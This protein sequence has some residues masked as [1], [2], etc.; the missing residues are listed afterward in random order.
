MGTV[1]GLS[2]AANGLGI[3]LGSVLGGLLEDRIDLAA[4]FLFGGAVMAVGTAVFLA[5][6]RGLETR[7]LEQML[8]VV[9]E[10]PVD[11]VTV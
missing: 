6:T 10:S 9:P 5:L 2:S 8:T 1:L 3:V 7:D 11:A 4:V